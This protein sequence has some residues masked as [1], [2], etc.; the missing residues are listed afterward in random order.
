[1]S[2]AKRSEAL[3]AKLDGLVPVRVEHAT[4][5]ATDVGG[6]LYIL[7]LAKTL[8]AVEIVHI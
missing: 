3:F 2:A 8:G 1:M 6:T 7:G 5:F 4:L